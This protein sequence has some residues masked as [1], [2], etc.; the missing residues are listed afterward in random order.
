MKKQ[1][2]SFIAMASTL[3]M[4]FMLLFPIL[5][6]SPVSCY[7]GAHHPLDPLSPKELTLVQTIVKKSY[8]PSSNNSIS[9]HYVGLD[10]PEKPTVLSWLS[11]PST[12]TLIPRR[13]PIYKGPGYPL[14]TADEQV[15]AIQLPLTYG[16]FIESAKKRD[17]NVSYAVCSTFTVGWYGGAER[18]KRV[19]KVQCYY[20]KDTVNLYLRPIEGIQIVVDLDKMEIVEYSDTFKIPVPK[21]DGTDYRFSEQK[22]PF[23]PRINGAAIMQTKGPGFEI[24]GHT[25]SW[26]EKWMVY[27]PKS[28]RMIKP[29]NSP[30]TLVWGTI[31]M[32]S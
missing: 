15:A 9:F 18:T 27:R 11:K 8:N 29:E 5:T 16:P 12:E 6:I 23:G 13:D 2:S 28:T 10:E 30:S 4:V 19:V 25:I 14:L 20:N 3:K 22:P 32:S 7:K 24:D 31:H 26:D 21:A 1:Q 17:L